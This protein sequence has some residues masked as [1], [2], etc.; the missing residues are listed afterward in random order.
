MMFLPSYLLIITKLDSFISYVMIF[1]FQCLIIS[2]F[3]YFISMISSS[4]LIGLMVIICYLFIFTY[5][6]LNPCIGNII[7]INRPIE[8]IPEYYFVS[9][10]IIAVICTV[11]GRIFEKNGEDSSRKDESF[12]IIIY[13]C[14]GFLFLDENGS[15]IRVALCS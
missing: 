2:S 9:H 3:Y 7:L 1:M 13:G 14:M 6:F 12:G 11:V 10:T 4:S 15:Q 5:I 8:Y